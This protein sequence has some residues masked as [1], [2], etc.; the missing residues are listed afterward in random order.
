MI[1]DPSSTV[2]LVLAPPFE[3]PLIQ[4]APD[5]RMRPWIGLT[6]D[7]FERVQLAPGPPPPAMRGRPASGVFQRYLSLDRVLVGENTAPVRTKD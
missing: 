3:L 6:D 1:E 5:A 7:S 4:H 2:P